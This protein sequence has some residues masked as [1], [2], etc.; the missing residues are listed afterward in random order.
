MCETLMPYVYGLACFIILQVVIQSFIIMLKQKYKMGLLI[1]ARPEAWAEGR[2][3][4][5]P[6]DPMPVPPRKAPSQ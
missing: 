5:C 2:Q 3:R 4:W 1:L 6:E